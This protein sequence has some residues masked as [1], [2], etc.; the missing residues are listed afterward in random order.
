MKK[1]IETE[2]ITIKPVT[3]KATFES[4]TLVTGGRPSG[5]ISD[6]YLKELVEGTLGEKFNGLTDDEKAAEMK[7]WKKKNI[8]VFRRMPNGQLAFGANQVKAALK[9]INSVHGFKINK[10]HL[11][12]GLYIAG[13][14][15]DGEQYIPIYRGEKPILSP[16]TY[17]ETE[18]PGTFLNPKSC[19]KSSEALM[20]PITFTVT[21][22][23][24]SPKLKPVIETMFKGIRAIGS[25]RSE[26]LGVVKLTKI[27]AVQ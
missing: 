24:S 9:E 12:H 7:R 14:I 21:A 15:V 1:I 16:D 20:P 3:Y 25:N 19:V 18:I 8:T 23:V 11:Q 17:H 26:Q 2:P 5:P 22:E 27:E 10:Q 13:E 6:S 4:E